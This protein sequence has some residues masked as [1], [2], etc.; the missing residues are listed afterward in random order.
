MINMLR[1]G[2]HIISYRPLCLW[3]RHVAAEAAFRNITIKTLLIPT[4]IL[5]TIKQVTPDRIYPS[6][7]N[8][9]V[10]V[11]GT[12]WVYEYHKNE[13]IE[14]FDRKFTYVSVSNTMPYLMYLPTELRPGDTLLLKTQPH[15]DLA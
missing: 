6:V 8:N 9:V 12:P 5:H 15:K 7:P 1:L 14:V 3:E 4:D 11:K 13:V 10:G 2:Y